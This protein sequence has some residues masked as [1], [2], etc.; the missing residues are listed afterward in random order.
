MEYKLGF[1]GKHK[2]TTVFFNLGKFGFYLNFDDKLYS[3]P[4]CFQDKK[5]NLESAIRT[6]DYKSKLIKEEKNLKL[7]QQFQPKIILKKYGSHNI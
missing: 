3:V 2:D 5:I 4:I 7:I 1:L 6:I